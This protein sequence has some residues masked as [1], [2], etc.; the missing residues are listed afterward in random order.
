MEKRVDGLIVAPAGGNDS[1]LAD[2]VEPRDFRWYL[3]IACCLASM[4]SWC[5]STIFAA[6][7][8]IV[9]HLI[10]LGYRRIAATEGVAQRQFD[11]R[12]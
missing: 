7:Q 9:E 10:G 12:A 8:H 4:P 3:S 2:L 1:Y 6:A 11:R 5:W